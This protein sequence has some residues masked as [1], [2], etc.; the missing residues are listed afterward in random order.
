MKSADVV[1]VGGGIAGLSA[2]WLLA[3]E[4]GRRVLLF[5]REPVFA[6]HSSGR[7]AAIFR[8]LDATP[9]GVELAIRSRT[10][11]DELIGPQGKW[12]ERTGALYVARSPAALQGMLGLARQFGIGHALRE[13][14]DLEARVP[15]LRGGSAAVGLES[16][17]DGV[18]DIHGI[19]CALA[20]AGRACGA[21]LISGTEVT[22]VRAQGGRIEGV[23][24]ADGE[25]VH[26]G[27]LV[28]AAGAWSAGL[29]QAASAPLPLQ[30]LRRHVAHLE[31]RPSPPTGLPVVWC[32]DDE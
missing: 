29:G 32:V 6:S 27:T 17:D 4:G 15:Y 14:S 8:H 5:E 22:E 25:L 9:G 20:E 23:R 12:L 28:L 1:I 7:N 31:T 26:A 30:P 19:C 2:A 13:R 18:M 10:L 3:R 11:L 24:L 16:F 21:Q